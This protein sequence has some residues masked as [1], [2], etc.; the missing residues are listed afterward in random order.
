MC[1]NSV[2]QKR[3]KQTDKPTEKEKFNIFGRPGG[4]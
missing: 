1:K 4:G 3:D 2:I